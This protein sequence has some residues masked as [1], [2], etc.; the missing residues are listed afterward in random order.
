MSPPYDKS[1]HFVDGYLLYLMAVA[2]ERASADFH[3]S[4]RDAGLRVPEWRVLACLVDQDALM[5]TELAE[6][7]LLEQSRMTK[8]VDQMH[9]RGF[10]ERVP[11]MS[12]RRRVRVRLTRQGRG[13]AANLVA[14]AKSHEDRL[15]ATLADTDAA[16]IK[17]VLQALLN[18]LK[19]PEQ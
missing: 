9:K 16:R 5:I 6:K 8:T 15:L 10:V 19:P 4:V 3:A 2:S 18:A 14:R 7:C 11:D 1:E 13:L 17:P 12:D